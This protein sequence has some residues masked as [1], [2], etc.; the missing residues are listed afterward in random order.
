MGFNVHIISMS[1]AFPDNQPAIKKAI[2]NAENDG[3][4]FFAAASN[5]GGNTSRLF[6]AKLD[7]VL[8]IHASDGHGNKSGMDPSPKMYSENISTLGVAIPSIWKDGVYLS[9]TSYSTPVAAGIAAN[10]LRFVQHV[11]DAGM[12]TQEQRNE[13]FSRTGIKNIMLA[14][15]EPRDQYQY[16]TPWRRMWNKDAMIPDVVTKIKEALKE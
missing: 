6:P 9:G 12:L 16:V 1:F 10:V 7:K 11:A 8:C 5:Y 15:S 14:M 3:S 4:V 13:A 2:E